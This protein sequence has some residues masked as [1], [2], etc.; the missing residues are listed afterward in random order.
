MK[1]KPTRHIQFLFVAVCIAS[2][3]CK[4][5]VDPNATVPFDLG[6]IPHITGAN[7]QLL[8]L[9]QRQKNR[10]DAEILAIKYVNQKDSTQ[11]EI[12]HPFIEFLYNGLIHIINSDLAKAQEV[13]TRF[14]IHARAP[15][16]REIVIYADTTAAWLDSWRK[17]KTMTGNEKID[18]LINLLNFCLWDYDELQ[19][20]SRAIATLHS[21]HA[22]NIYAVGR[23]FERLNAIERA[24]PDGII[25]DGNGL[26]VLFFNDHLQYRFEYGYGDCPSGCI[27][28][29]LWKFN[30][31]SDG[32]VAFAGEEGPLPKSV[33]YIKN[34]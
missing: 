3:S 14:N 11:I 27:N 7:D 34:Q 24:G 8:T 17:G 6:N 18:S 22:F 9:E 25:G 19:S 10:R 2:S 5:S 30:V 13:T 15:N 16:P 21:D 33:A 20:L 12:P 4:L 31:Y 28:H 23:L 29:H 1:Q 26:N 32:T